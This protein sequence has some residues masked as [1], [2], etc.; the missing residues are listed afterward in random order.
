MR[1]EP[2]RTIYPRLPDIMD[3]ETLS[4]VTV[5]EP[6]ERAFVDKAKTPRTKYLNALYLKAMAYLG[7]SRIKPGQ[8]PRL[9]RLRLAQELGLDKEF[10][11]ILKI[12]SVKKSRIITPI[13]QF[14][15]L[16]RY[17]RTARL[18][19][20]KWLRQNITANESD[21]LVVVNETIRWFGEQ[22]IE[23][24]VFQVAVA[25][26]QTALSDVDKQLQKQIF[27]SFNEQQVTRLKDVLLKKDGRTPFDRFKDPVGKASSI[28]LQAELGRLKE[29]S[30]ILRG[31]AL[32]QSV[33][34]RKVDYFADIAVRSTASEINQLILSRR[35]AILY[36]YLTVR[37]SQLL[38]SA[39]EALIQI[40]RTTASKAKVHAN[41]YRQALADTQAEYEIVLQDLLEI[42]CDSTTDYDLV[43]QIRKYRT[44]DEYETLRDEVKQ[45]TSWNECYYQ[46]LQ[47]HYTSLRRFLPDWYEI[48]P[49]VTTTADNS[50]VKA[51]NFLKTHADPKSST[52]PPAEIPTGFLSTKWKRR[53]L[54]TYSWADHIARVHKAP[55]ELGLI[56]AIV[57][58]LTNGTL[59]IEGALRFAPMTQH[60]IDR[61]I[62][63]ANYHKYLKKLDC[64][65]QAADFYTPLIE[66]LAQSLARFDQNYESVYPIFRANRS[67]R[68]SYL[69]SSSKKPLKRIK[70][71]TNTVKAYLTPATIM[72]VILDCYKLTGFLDLFRPMRRRQT[73]DDE[74]WLRAM[75]ATLYAYGCNCGPS[76]ASQAT[77][78]SKQSIV[79]FRRHYMGTPQLMQAASFI[80]DAYTQTGLSQYLKDPGVFMTD[81]MHFP[82]LENSLGARHYFRNRSK[83]NVL[84]YQHV[85]A[86]C[87]CLF[88]KA[89]LC[90]V[91][92]AVH[93]LGGAVNQTT[94]YDSTV[95]ICDNAGRSDL[96][97]GIVPF[98]NIDGLLPKSV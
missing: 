3:S 69:R 61:N 68:L 82:T 2:T 78:V 51:I 92:E 6:A 62:F 16:Q 26:A 27:R 64:P 32:P 44:L 28:N 11:N 96:V 70:K 98:L 46:K 49:I 34:R 67:G 76:Q 4:L 8:L 85:T 45:T 83:K 86:D 37:R 88:T 91:S 1:V 33:S 17:S 36:C 56:E 31:I 80:A 19:C 25:I 21:L 24:P 18:Q 57:K 9:F 72:E 77:G 30:L 5:L 66:R 60:L 71:L 29:L 53:A 93:M 20:T 38:D 89:L 75:L 48:I 84:L 39:A 10:A 52:L 50:V 14:L 63:L 12:H 15:G 87:I 55:Y 7:H 97:F 90:G 58:G 22:S 79:Y 74:Q 81:A 43:R 23:L 47:D 65:A 94:R 40:W 54:V 41:D 59:A 35:V 42:I 13:R 95:N 73:M